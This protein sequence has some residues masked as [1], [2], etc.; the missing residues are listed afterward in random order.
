M[1]TPPRGIT[2]RQPVESWKI[3]RAKELRRQQT[4]AEAKL[5]F[6]LK[7]NQLGYHFRRQQPI[8]GFIADFYCH[9]AALVI[10][11]DGPVHESRVEQDVLKA[12]VLE[13]EG[14]LVMRFLNDEVLNDMQRVLFQIRKVCA[15]RAVSGSSA[16]LPS[17][18]S[19]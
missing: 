1:A 6:R 8:R 12:K 14:L 10:E 4:P 2:T 3:T 16:A 5:W 19:R 9:T 13:A 18:T 7:G 11:L 15:Q 17:Q